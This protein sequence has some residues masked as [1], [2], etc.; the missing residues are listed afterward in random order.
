MSFYCCNQLFFLRVSQ[1][2]I[3]FQID[4][5][6]LAE[7]VGKCTCIQSH[8][9]EPA[10]SEIG[11]NVGGDETGGIELLRLLDDKRNVAIV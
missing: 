10:P 8:L 3:V 9:D 7:V 6:V 5:Y 2:Q 11:S 1:R 4:C